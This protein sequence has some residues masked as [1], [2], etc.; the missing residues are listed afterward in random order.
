MPQTG[1]VVWYESTSDRR[2]TLVVFSTELGWMAC[3]WQADLVDAVTFGHKTANQASLALS[4]S[5]SRASQYDPTDEQVA[6]M[7]RLTAY[8]EGTPDDFHD[9][10]LNLTAMTPFQKRVVNRCR[11]I[12]W[13]RKM[14]YGEFAKVGG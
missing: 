4:G 7:E 12:P 5:W 10:P 8:A 13:G 9:V 14:S 11:R 2:Q 3:R 6:L 1:Q